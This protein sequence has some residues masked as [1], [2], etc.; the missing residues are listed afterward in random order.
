MGCAS[1]LATRS[2]GKR[3]L[4]S[5]SRMV[6]ISDA[7]FGKIAGVAT[8]VS[9]VCCLS[10]Q[11]ALKKNPLRCCFVST[12]EI[13]KSP[14]NHLSKMMSIHRNHEMFMI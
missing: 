10:P 12:F 13:S 11:V 6:N 1:P 2:S 14:S 9:L 7:D 8:E 4:P 5:R 3:S